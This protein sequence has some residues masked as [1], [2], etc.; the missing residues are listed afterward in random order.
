VDN[1]DF[2]GELVG[3]GRSLISVT[4]MA[5]IFSGVFALFL[6]VTGSFLPHDISFLKMQPEELCAI[7]ECRIVHF[8]FHDRVAFGGVLVAIGSLYLWIA[9]FPLRERLAWAWWTLAI[10]GSAGFASFLCYLGYGY[11]DSWHG[12]ATLA[13][14][15]CFVTGMFL[16]RRMIDGKS[17]WRCVFTR[18]IP[19]GRNSRLSLGRACLLA[20][21]LGMIGGGMVI[22]I[23]GMTTVFVPQDI[24]YMGLP[25][26]RLQSINPR[27]IPLIAHDRAGFGGGLASCGILVVCIVWNAHPSRHLWQVLSM[28]GVA[29]FGCAI[30]VHYHIGYTD[31]LHL[32]PA[33]LGAAL[34]GTGMTLCRRDM[35]SNSPAATG[36]DIPVSP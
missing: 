16:T 22:M 3:D 1:R 34:F 8:M 13:L 12:V 5:L 24:A 35:L 15:P 23:I 29:G 31:L 21:G 10:S 7:N 36:R 6:S 18:G 26:D 11:L 4:G 2:I 30:A 32:A 17:T 27:L 20:T 25:P 28:A 9:A 33:W 19:I 14:L